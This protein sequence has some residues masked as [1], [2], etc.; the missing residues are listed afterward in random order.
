[1]MEWQKKST[2][3]AWNNTWITAI[4]RWPEYLSYTCIR[5]GVLFY[6]QLTLIDWGKFSWSNK[7]KVSMQ[8]KKKNQNDI[9]CS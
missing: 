1:M 5:E 9:F 2:L 6:D 8:K 4:E 7:E 3:Y